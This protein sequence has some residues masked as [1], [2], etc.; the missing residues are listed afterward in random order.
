MRLCLYLNCYKRV[1]LGSCGAARCTFGAP[2]TWTL[3]GVLHLLEETVLTYRAQ[4]Q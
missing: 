4:R 1:A 2:L 3:A